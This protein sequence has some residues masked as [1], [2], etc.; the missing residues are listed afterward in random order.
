LSTSSGNTSSGN[1]SSGNRTSGD[2]DIWKYLIWGSGH[3]HTKL[4]RNPNYQF[5]HLGH[6]STDTGYW[7]LPPNDQPEIPKNVDFWP[8]PKNA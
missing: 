7:K 3:Y 5:L 6:Q 8:G 4:P 2:L 1:T